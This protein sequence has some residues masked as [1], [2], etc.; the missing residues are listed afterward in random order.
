MTRPRTP[1]QEMHQRRLVRVQRDKQLP[2]VSP[3]RLL[4]GLRL[5]CTRVGADEGRLG[6]CLFVQ[7]GERAECAVAAGDGGE[8]FVKFI[9]L[10][11]DWTKTRLAEHGLAAGSASR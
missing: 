10:N 2:R 7:T 9:D 5:G 3:Q 11:F 4:S 6:Q 1:H 8:R